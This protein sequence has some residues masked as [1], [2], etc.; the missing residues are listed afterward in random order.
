LDDSIAAVLARAGVKIG[1][2][3]IVDP[4]DHYF[5]D[6]QMIA[7]SRYGTHPVTR[8]LSLS[9]YPGA[10]PLET[11]AAPDVRVVPLALSSTES[12][13]ISDRLG[14]RVD[15]ETGPPTARIIVLASEGRIT[16][17]A[18][19]FRLIV[20][21]DADFVSNSFFPYLGNSDVV[22]AG[23]AWLTREERAPTMKPPVEVLPTVTLT[24]AQM[25]G[26]FIVTVL[27]ANRW[28]CQSRCGGGAM[29]VCWIAEVC[30]DGIPCA[31]SPGPGG[32]GPAPFTPAGPRTFS[33]RRSAR[34]RSP[35]VMAVVLCAR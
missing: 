11:V 3:V 13:I 5:T 16:E 10:R 23:I 2:G 8:G 1:D 14:K 29:T 35:A 19:P 12:S 24:G 26:I 27:L 34:P 33:Q 32:P 28:L 4:R 6:E 20:A 22:L 21:G 15:P 30:R 17:A 18:N 7:V 25:R 9:F 31:F